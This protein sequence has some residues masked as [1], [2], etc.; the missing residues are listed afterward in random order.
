MIVAAPTPEE[1]RQ[2]AS[3]RGVGSGVG[4]GSRGLDGSGLAAGSPGP[5]SPGPCSPGPCLHEASSS[6]EDDE[7]SLSASASRTWPPAS[8]PP[9]A[10]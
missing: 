3:S 4:E 2:G 10:K 7:L 1:G 5:C 6:G 9:R 8:T